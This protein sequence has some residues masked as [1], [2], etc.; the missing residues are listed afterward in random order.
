M[1]TI[2]SIFESRKAVSPKFFKQPFVNRGTCILSA[3]PGGEALTFAL[4]MN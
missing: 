4:N 2:V 3:F 1:F